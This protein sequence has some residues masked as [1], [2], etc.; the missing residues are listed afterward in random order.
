MGRSKRNRNKQ[1]ENEPVKFRDPSTYT[2]RAPP[3]LENASFEKYYREQGILPL[4]FDE[5]MA[6]LKTSLPVT[7]RFTGNRSYASDLRD[8]MTTSLFPNLEGIVLD[9]TPLK[10][11]TSVN[12][13]LVLIKVS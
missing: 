8:F 1:K 11:P 3:I 13:Y 6:C 7:F 9:G 4:E 2:E 10:K 5:F 12:W